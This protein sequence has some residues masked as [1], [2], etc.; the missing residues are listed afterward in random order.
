MKLMRIVK[1]R[2]NLSRVNFVSVNFRALEFQYFKPNFG[3]WPDILD[4]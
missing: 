1:I 2:V 4:T 3:T